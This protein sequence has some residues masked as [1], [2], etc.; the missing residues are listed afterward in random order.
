MLRAMSL[1]RGFGRRLRRARLRLLRGV[2]RHYLSAV[3]ALVLVGVFGV[4]ATSASFEVS[5]GTSRRN[6][7]GAAFTPWA[8]ATPDIMP[9][10]A[11]TPLPEP[12]LV[13]Y[14]VI[15][16][17]TQQTEIEMAVHADTVVNGWRGPAPSRDVSRV[18]IVVR[19]FRDE[20]EALEVLRSFATMPPVG[21]P[22]IS[23]VDLR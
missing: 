4:A 2:R 9:L 13:V 23:V 10:A 21:G 20:A 3:S 11:A 1:T 14:Y 6:D 15:G 16:S 19:D 18:Y 22:S 17:E 5:D 12:R 8:T 7:A